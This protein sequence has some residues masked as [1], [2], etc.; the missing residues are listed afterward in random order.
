MR[1]TLKLTAVL[2]LVIAC[3]LLAQSFMHVS[4]VRALHVEEA[5]DDLEILARA[6]GAATGEIW[7]A[8]GE[9]RARAYINKADERRART[10]I[11]FVADDIGPTAV[12]EEPSPTEVR[13]QALVT[14]VQVYV[15][16]APAAR[17]ELH[18]TRRAERDFTR[19]LMWTQT[20]TVAAIVGACGALALLLGFWLVGRPVARL[21]D[22]ARS[23]ARGE[24]DTPDLPQSR[25]ELGKLAQEMNAMT[26]DLANAQRRAREERRRRTQAFEQLRHAD[27]LGTVGKIASGIAHE[28]GTPL[29]V[30]SGRATLIASDADATDRIRNSANTIVSQSEHMEGIVRQLLDFSRRK[31]IAP[32]REE[33]RE[34]LEHAAALAEPLAEEQDVLVEVAAGPN[35]AASLDGGK[36]LQVLTNLIVNAIQAMPDGGVVRVSTELRSVDEPP[37]RHAAPGQFVCFSVHDEG[38]GIETDDLEHVFQPFFTTKD[39]GEGTGL[40]LSVS[41][42]IVREHGGWIEVD[43]EPGKGSTFRVFLPIG[44]ES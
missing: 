14:Y 20:A 7:A 19:Q 36:T 44:D 33:P 38:V 17:L 29:N 6:L 24:F 41:H 32:T 5:R 18:R 21:I 2:S 26:H 30:V 16:G 10:R 23:V 8:S 39:A 11:R 3:G 31:E 9:Q 12:G 34:L 43:S 40:G 25:D 15:S 42:G 28:L 4:R 37:D 27:R 35:I 13:D 22:H 1:L